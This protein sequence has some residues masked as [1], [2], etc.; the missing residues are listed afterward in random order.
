MYYVFNCRGVY[1]SR[2]NVCGKK[3]NWGE[4]EKCLL[5][6]KRGKLL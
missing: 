4:K 1:S 2:D 3:L 5:K 6:E